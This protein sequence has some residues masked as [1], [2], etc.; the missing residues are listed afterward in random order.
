MRQH[1][2][3]LLDALSGSFTRRLFVNVFHGSDRVAEELAFESWS[4]EGDFGSEVTV[5]GS[6]VVV[7]PSESGESMS[8]VGTWGVLSPF[9]ARLELVME[10]TA[11]SFRERVT[12]GMFRVTRIPDARDFTAVVNGA[13]VVVSSRVRVEFLSLEEDVRRRGFRF[14]EE[15]PSLDSCYNELRRITGIPV[16]ESVP[17]APIPSGTLWEAKQGGRLDAVTVLGDVLGGTPV[18]NSRGAWVVVP[19]E[20][21]GP[22]GK[23]TLGTTGTVIDVGYEV[24]SDGVY[25]CVVGTF[26]D[27]DRNPLYAVAEVSSGDLAT[28]GLYLETT[29]YYSNDAIKTQDAANTAVQSVLDL[30]IGSQQYDVPIQC[31]VNPLV[32]C[33]DVVSLSGWS[34]PLVGRLVKFSMSD[35]PLMN[36]TLRVF[37]DL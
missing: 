11:G 20:L 27:D 7:Y 21:T 5:S 12:L 6:G 22:V 34:R 31:H 25:N 17:D 15:P 24:D 29:R 16:E 19:D 35:S 30:S 13:E 32:E 14:P 36:V 3:Q 1:S 28:S 4:L 9:R 8:P 33:G 10:V 18:V 2:E 26:E 37:R 23:L